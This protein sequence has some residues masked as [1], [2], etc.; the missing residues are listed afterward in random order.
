[1]QKGNCN[2][3]IVPPPRATTKMPSE[4]KG[5]SYINLQLMWYRAAKN[6]QTAFHICFF[7][8][9]LIFNF[10]LSFIRIQSTQLL[11]N[12]AFDQL[13]LLPTS[14]L[15]L[16]S[17]FFSFLTLTPKFFSGRVLT[18]RQLKTCQSLHYKEKEL[19]K[20]LKKTL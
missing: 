11:I 17:V 1:M 18:S 8:V 3:A 7:V 15:I 2:S 12:S 9:K 13:N 5:P 14:V 6:R 16:L 20:I 4:P 19:K 10:S